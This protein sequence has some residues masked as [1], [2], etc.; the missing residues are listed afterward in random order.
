MLFG[1]TQGGAIL[2]VSIVAQQ[3]PGRWP[4]VSQ[5][6]SNIAGK[7]LDAAEHRPVL[8]AYR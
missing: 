7:M 1:P 6:F 2:R 3:L 4:V 8:T 5:Y